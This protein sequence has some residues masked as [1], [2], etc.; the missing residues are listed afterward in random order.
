MAVVDT[1]HGAVLANFEVFPQSGPWG[2]VVVGDNGRFV[3]T[4]G[5][6]M[7]TVSIIDSGS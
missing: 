5:S 3:Y 6:A 4:V 2:G 1:A 7:R